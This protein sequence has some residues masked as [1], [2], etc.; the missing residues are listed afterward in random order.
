M[1]R[2]LR[3]QIMEM[4]FTYERGTIRNCLNCGRGHVSRVTD[5]ASYRTESAD[6]FAYSMKIV[7]AWKFIA[8]RRSY[9]PSLHRLTRSP[10]P[11]SGQTPRRTR[12]HRETINLLHKYHHQ[13]SLIF[14]VF[15]KLFPPGVGSRYDVHQKI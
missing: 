2:T 11:I 15:R 6:T 13:P 4:G 12:P 7:A 14:L 5:L 10:S 8:L 1:S 3:K 9:R